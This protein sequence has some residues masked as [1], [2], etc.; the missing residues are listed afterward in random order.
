[1]FTARLVHLAFLITLTSLLAVAQTLPRTPDGKPDLQGIWQATTTAADNLEDHV[2][3]LEILAGRSV[4][5]GGTIPYQPWAAEQR[6]ENYRNRLTADPLAQCYIPSVPRIMY[7]PFPF[8]IFQTPD[9]IALTFEWTLNY[10]LIHTDGTPHPDDIGLWMGNSRGHWEGDVLVTDVTDFNGNTWFD[11]AGNFHSDALNVVERLQMTDPN[12]IRYQATIE[13]EKV[14][15]EPWTIEVNLHR[16]LDRD[17]LFEYSC[18]SEFEE[19]NG[20]FTPEERTWYPGSPEAPAMPMDDWPEPAP[21]AP[22]DAVPDLRRTA[23]GK[24]DLQGFYESQTR[25]ANQGLERTGLIVD[26]SDHRLP[27]QPWAREEQ[28]SRGTDERGYDDPTAHCFPAG[29]PR[30][31]WVPQGI[32]FIQTPD[33]LVMLFERTSWR[34]I[35]I[36]PDREHLPDYMRLWQG[37]S[38]GHWEGDTLVIDTTNINGKTWLSEHGDFMSYAEHVVERLTPVGPNELRY[39]ATVI[40]PVAYTRPWTIS[41]PILREDFEFREAACHEEDRD[42]PHMKAIQ[43]AARAARQS[44]N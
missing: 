20:A 27:L 15:T 7:M 36:D 19:Q 32:Q 28:A 17:R 39:S 41:Y 10:R 26:P 12:T 6:A 1:M 3:D 5:L 21:L 13:D 4:V 16:R 29:V 25:G 40:D 14:F 37:D 34:I 18:Q 30:S 22:A 8:Q 43:D 31:M 44:Q 35:P 24:P 42:L 2:A 9:A 33:Y 11:K 38:I 23:E